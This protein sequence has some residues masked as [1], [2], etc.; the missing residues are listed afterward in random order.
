MTKAEL[1]Q[2]IDELPDDA[3]EGASVL[4]RRVV[5]NQLDPTQA[6]AWSQ[7]WQAKLD[8]SLLDIQNGRVTQYSSGE[9]FLE[10]L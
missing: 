5:L 2:I 8:A 9:E 10:A 6:W 1:H 7:E 4:L 3:V